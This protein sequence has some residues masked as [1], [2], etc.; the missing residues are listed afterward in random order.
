MGA[1]CRALR[2]LG[3]VLDP[4]ELSVTLRREVRDRLRRADI[5]FV[6][7]GN[8]FFLLQEIRR[9]GAA[10]L[11]AEHVAAGKP[12]LGASAG[13][14]V[15]APDIT[16]VQLMDDPRVAPGLDGDFTALGIVPFSVVPHHAG[17]PFR[18]AT[19]RILATYS[20]ALDLRPISNR[21]VVAVT[22]G[23]VEVL[24]APAGGRA[25]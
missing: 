6:T 15:L 21:Q 3:C 14:M 1:D 25:A 18:R 12:Y 11:I 20:S 8:T 17:F 4:V 9:T 13:S 7:G 5:L 10:P 2:R 16:Y 24:T 23:R 19:R 22:G